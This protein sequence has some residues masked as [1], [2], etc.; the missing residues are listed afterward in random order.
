MQSVRCCGSYL[1]ITAGGGK[2]KLGH[3][4][5]IV[6]VNQVVGYSG[7]VRFFNE[8]FFE[9]GG[10]FLSIGVII[11]VGVDEGPCIE[12]LR[13]VVVGILQDEFFH[14]VVKGCASVIFFAFGVG[15]EFAHG[16][17]ICALAAGGRMQMLS[18]LDLAGAL[19]AARDVGV[20]TPFALRNAPVSHSAGRILCKNLAEGLF[21]RV[22][23]EGMKQGDSAFE[24]FLN[25][26]GARGWEVN[27]SQLLRS[28]FV[29]M[30]ALVGEAWQNYYERRKESRSSKVTK[31]LVHF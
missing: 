20:P 16:A 17:E 18:S 28:E 24:I 27:C 7:I 3:S 14:R 9:D 13:F 8:K 29:L 15:I 5:D 2:A 19:L 10:S 12:G 6:A 23:R 26:G 21:S 4:G 31:H 11:V 30:M 25:T 1:R 22:E